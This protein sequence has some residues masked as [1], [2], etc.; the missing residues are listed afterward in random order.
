MQA[1]IRAHALLRVK[2]FAAVEGRAMR[3]VLQAVGPRVDTHYDR[4][5]APGEAR[6]GRLVVIGLAGID[7]A[8]VAR[9]LAG[10]AALQPAG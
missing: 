8:A 10:E 3:L 5:W 9:A 1:A 6:D 2:G 7:R 4:P